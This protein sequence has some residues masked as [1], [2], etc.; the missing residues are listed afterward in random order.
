MIRVPYWLQAVTVTAQAA[1]LYLAGSG[2]PR[3]WLLAGVQSLVWGAYG[4]VTGQWPILVGMAVLLAV[5]VRNYRHALRGGG[6]VTKH[7]RWLALAGN[8]NS[9]LDG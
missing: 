4:T 2:R 8:R 5:K 6:H 9:G 3:G 1:G 7:Q